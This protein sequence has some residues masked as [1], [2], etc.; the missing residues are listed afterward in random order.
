MIW[1]LD[2]SLTL[3]FIF[4]LQIPVLLTGFT[5]S[6]PPT[7]PPNRSS[8][9]DHIC[10]SFLFRPG[11]IFSIFTLY[12][13]L[14]RPVPCYFLTDANY[15]RI[16]KTK[17]FGNALRYIAEKKNKG[18]MKWKPKFL[19]SVLFWAFWINCKVTQI[20]K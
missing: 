6:H 18:P 4:W 10:F 20:V 3:D 5:H 8:T 11:Y 19:Y 15:F 17:W 1:N 16:Y 9:M 13:F 2:Q 14:P 12:C 7:I